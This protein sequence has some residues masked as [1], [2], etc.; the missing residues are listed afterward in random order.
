MITSITA[1]QTES[2]LTCPSVSC[3]IEWGPPAVCRIFEIHDVNRH[4]LIPSWCITPIGDQNGIPIHKQPNLCRT[5]LERKTLVLR[6]ELYSSSN[7]EATDLLTAGLL[8]DPSRKLFHNLSSWP[9]SFRS[10]PTF[11]SS[12]NNRGN[13]A[14]TSRTIRV[15]LKHHSRGR[16]IVKVMS[17]LGNLWGL[18]TIYLSLA[19]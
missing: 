1:K 14:G 15:L 6:D 3:G 11:S 17:M 12:H 10:R 7:S 4:V 16:H 13:A 19:D 8:P 18:Q 2:G 9:S 5:A